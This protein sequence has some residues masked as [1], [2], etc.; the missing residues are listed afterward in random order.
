MIRPFLVLIS[1]AFY[2]QTKAQDTLTVMQ[3]NM[4]NYGNYTSYC[5]SD[6][7]NHEQKD[8]YLRTI[9]NF[10]NPDIFTVNEMSEYEFYHNRILTDVLN[11]N[12]KDY[13]NK[14]EITNIAGSYIINGLFY[15]SRKFVLHSQYV[16]Q[17]YVRD[18]NVY[19]LYYRHSSLAQGDTTYLNCIVAHLKSST[20]SSNEQSRATMA[21]NTLNWL[22]NNM[23]PGNYLLMGDFN[24]YS[25]DEAAYQYFINPLPAT[26]DYKFYDPINKPG[27]WNNDASFA[28]WHTQSVSGSGTSCQASGGMDDRFDFILASETIMQGTANVRYIP[29]TYKALGQDGLHFNK[30]ITDS[31]QNNTVPNDVLNALGANSDHLPIILKLQVKAGPTGIRNAIANINNAEIQYWGNEHFLRINSSKDQQI[32]ATIVSLTGNVISSET[33]YLFSGNNKLK[34]NTAHLARGMYLL[35]LSGANGGNLTLKLVR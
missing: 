33:A 28:A 15:D 9:L 2:F 11:T 7:N 16:A 12:E 35:N 17:S 21:S 31:P 25:S 4:L 6:N 27:D 14:A 29:D 3:Y 34:L 30:S 20:G 8:I 22:K 26:E 1:C 5:T 32:Q 24:L 18:I 23:P 19:K 13:Y 10:V